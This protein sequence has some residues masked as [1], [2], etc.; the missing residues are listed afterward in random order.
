MTLQLHYNDIMAPSCSLCLP[1][2]TCTCAVAWLR[3]E[4]LPSHRSFCLQVSVHPQHVQIANDSY[5]LPANFWLN[6]T[7][8]RIHTNF[9]HVLRMLSASS[10]IQRNS[11]I[12]KAECFIHASRG[13]RKSENKSAV[14]LSS[15][16]RV[17]SKP[18]WDTTARHWQQLNATDDAICATTCNSCD[19]DNDNKPSIT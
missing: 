6:N 8:S 13:F 2:A 7:H 15:W 19:H 11:P 12:F 14:Q 3:F 17:T 4:Q 9:C 5:S 16:S 1:S 18:I 10:W